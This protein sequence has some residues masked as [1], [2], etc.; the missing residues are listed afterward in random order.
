MIAGFVFS[1]ILRVTKEFNERIK[2]Y[3]AWS[4][5]DLAC[6]SSGL[7]FNGYDANDQPKWDLMTNFKFMNIEV[8]VFG[9]H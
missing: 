6:N 8:F 5:G 1:E 9:S 7:G 4:L 3:F 2:F